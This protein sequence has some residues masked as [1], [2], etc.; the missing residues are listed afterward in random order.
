MIKHATAGAFVFCDFPDGWRLGLVEHP[1]MGVLA[2]PGGHV[3]DDESQ[4]QA[5]IREVEEETGLRGVRLLEPPAPALPAGFPDTHAR[6]PLP[7]WIT[8]MR[9]PADNHLSEKHVHVDHVWVGIASDPHPAEQPA[10]P[11]AWYTAEEIQELPMFEDAR[12]LAKVLFT[13]VADLSA[14]NLGGAEI[15]ASFATAGR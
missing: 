1:R 3:E 5:A 9:V 4:A 12:L 7:W 14:E 10:H 15:A 11:F 13:C 8:E 2:C 6:V